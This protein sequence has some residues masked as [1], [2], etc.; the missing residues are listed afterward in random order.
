[1]AYATTFVQESEDESG[2]VNSASHHLP[3]LLLAAKG[4]AD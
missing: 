1:M 2:Q 3:A 4:Q